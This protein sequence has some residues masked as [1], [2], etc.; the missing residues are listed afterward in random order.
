M[1]VPIMPGA[2]EGAGRAQRHPPLGAG[3]AL[4]QPAALRRDLGR[5][6]AGSAASSR[7]SRSPSPP[8]PATAAP[9]RRSAASPIRIWSSAAT[10]G[11]SS[12][13]RIWPGDK[14]LC[15]RQ[16]FDYKVSNTAL[17]RPDLLPA[18]RHPLHQPAWRADRAATLDGDPLPGARGDR[19]AALRRRR[20]ASRSGPTSSS[21]SSRPRSSR[22]SRRSTRSATTSGCCRA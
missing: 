7:R 9:R 22:S 4:S 18:R 15:H 19:E 16:P 11:G 8:T 13:A 17:R 3:D 2:A 14:M 21:R 10:S 12:K 6:R 5:A 1:G 20:P